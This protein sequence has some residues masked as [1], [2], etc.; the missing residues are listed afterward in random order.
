M[1]TGVDLAK[2]DR[3]VHVGVILMGGFVFPWPQVWHQPQH[4]G[5]VLNFVYQRDGST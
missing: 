4:C 2:P 5:L 1:P 3:L